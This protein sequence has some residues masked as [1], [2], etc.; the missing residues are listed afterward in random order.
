[1]LFFSAQNFFNFLRF[2]LHSHIIT[3]SQDISLFLPSEGNKQIAEGVH[4]IGKKG[5]II[6]NMTFFKQKSSFFFIINR[7]KNFTLCFNVDTMH[8]K[9]KNIPLAFT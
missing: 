8:Y 3:P 4:Q 2:L 5:E 6:A 7:S 1:M 9:D